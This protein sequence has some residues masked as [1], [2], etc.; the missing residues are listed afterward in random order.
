MSVTPGFMLCAVNRTAKSA[1]NQNWN[2]PQALD[3]VSVEKQSNMLSNTERRE[4]S[5]DK[6]VSLFRRFQGDQTSEFSEMNI[7]PKAYSKSYREETNSES[8]GVFKTKG[9]SLFVDPPI[10]EDLNEQSASPSK[11]T[12]RMMTEEFD[13]GDESPKKKEREMQERLKDSLYFPE[14]ESRLQGEPKR[15][16]DRP[17]SQERYANYGQ[18][19][20]VSSKATILN[21]IKK[22]QLTEEIAE[23]ETYQ[24]PYNSYF[25]ANSANNELF[26]RHYD[27]H[28]RNAQ[29][30]AKQNSSSTSFT[31]QDSERLKS[32]RR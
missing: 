22:G 4:L 7:R 24:P 17:H 3:N 2:E 32:R 18:E 20:Q 30:T 15:L 5:D 23:R 25:R 10:V 14:E 31:N 13:R 6:S 1:I 8:G 9:L 29:W 21:K 27:S 11:I 28:G 19:Y 12:R 26:L 16:I